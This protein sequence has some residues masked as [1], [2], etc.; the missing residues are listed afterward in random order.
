MCVCVCVTV[1]MCVCECVHECLCLPVCLCETSNPV[2]LSYL[3][4]EKLCF[5]RADVSINVYDRLTMVMVMFSTGAGVPVS[6]VAIQ[7]GLCVEADGGPGKTQHTEN[8]GLRCHHYASFFLLQ[9]VNV[10]A[11]EQKFLPPP[12]Q[13]QLLSNKCFKRTEELEKQ[14]IYIH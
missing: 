14:G 1:S 12:P 9:C 13:P 7:C 11:N 5:A 10:S 2:S 6:P 3:L 4:S 8:P